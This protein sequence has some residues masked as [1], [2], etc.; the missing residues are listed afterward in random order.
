MEEFLLVHILTSIFTEILVTLLNDG[1]SPQ[2]GKTILLPG[3]VREMFTNQIP[4]HPNFARRRLP[5]VKEGLIYPV[6]EL[7]P[8][9]PGTTDR[10]AWLVRNRIE[11][12]YNLSTLGRQSW[13]TIDRITCGDSSYA[14]LNAYKLPSQGGQLYT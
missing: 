9:C 2:T 14:Y 3:T 6:E 7:Y 1:T 4:Q 12:N 10:I 13:F 5:A 8:L 11:I